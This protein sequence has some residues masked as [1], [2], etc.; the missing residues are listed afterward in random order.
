MDSQ[1][2]EIIK[3]KEIVKEETPVKK[4]KSIYTVE[5]R[6]IRQRRQKREYYY[7]NRERLIANAKQYQLDNRKKASD[8]M[9]ERYHTD[10]VYK[11]TV[12]SYQKKYMNKL[13]K[14]YDESVSI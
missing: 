3:E 5:E 2:N 14:A 12:K 1:S 13:K 9:K 6:A 10:P 8:R 11:A 7:R 4:S